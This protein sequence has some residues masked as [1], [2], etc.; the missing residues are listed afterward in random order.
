MTDRDPRFHG[1]LT[2]QDEIYQWFKQ[3]PGEHHRMDLNAGILAQ[4]PKW[5][6]RA[7]NNLVFS[8]SLTKTFVDHGDPQGRRAGAYYRLA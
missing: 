6:D 3:N 1:L 8:R 4:H 2:A 5:A 7:M